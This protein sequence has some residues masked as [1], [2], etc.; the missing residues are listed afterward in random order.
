MCKETK[1]MTLCQVAP[2]DQDDGEFGGQSLGAQAITCL[3]GK[4]MVCLEICLILM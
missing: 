3:G 2:S 4:K 1:C